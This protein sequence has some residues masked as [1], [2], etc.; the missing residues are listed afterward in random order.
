MFKK[1]LPLFLLV[2]SVSTIHAQTQGYVLGFNGIT[3]LNVPANTTAANIPVDPSQFSLDSQIIASPDG[4]R[5]YALYEGNA[6]VPSKILVID[7]ASNTPVATISNVGAAP[8]GLAITPD[9]AHIYVAD[10]LNA[11]FIVDTATNT[12][13]PTPI[14]VGGA[15]STL[16]VTPDGTRVYVA[17][18][19][20]RSVS[21]ISTATNTVVG[22]PI[23]IGCIPLSK[24]TVTPDGQQVYVG[25]AAPGQ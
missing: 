12:V 17:Q 6:S 2:L 5:V 23:P 11:V 9:G 13:E 16:I 4:S 3:V 25:C 22:S 18:E 7:A 20:G 15:P 8:L 1:F 19:T 24:M 21:V 10:Q 14:P